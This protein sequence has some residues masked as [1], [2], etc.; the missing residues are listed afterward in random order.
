MAGFSLRVLL[1]DSQDRLLR[2]P[3]T[4]LGHMIEDPEST[5]LIQFS[6]QRVRSVEG[7]VRLIDAKPATLVRITHDILTFDK[8]GRLDRQLLDQHQMARFEVKLLPE[9]RSTNSENKV[10]DASSKFLAKGG[11]WTPSRGMAKA[12][13][14]ALLDRTKCPRL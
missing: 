1:I 12:I 14:D 9:A 5:P 3:L 10:F 2:L 13:E 11:Q 4:K 8:H 7:I 6:N